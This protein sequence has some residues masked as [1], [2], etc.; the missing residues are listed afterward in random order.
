MKC[1]RVDELL[2]RSVT[3]LSWAV[4]GHFLLISG[5]RSSSF[6]DRSVSGRNGPT[7]QGR[8]VSG[9]AAC[10]GRVHSGTE[11][12]FREGCLLT[13]IVTVLFSS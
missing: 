6:V 10:T 2:P 3:G 11:R 5:N 4:R 12:S 1:R 13:A 9:C 8:R 7:T